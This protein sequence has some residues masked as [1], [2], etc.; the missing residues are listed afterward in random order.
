MSRYSQQIFLIMILIGLSAFFYL[1]HYQIFKDAHHIFIYMLGDIAFVFFEVML[2][3]V[4]IHEM[5]NTR[6]KRNRMEKLNVVIGIFFSEIGTDLLTYLSDFDPRLDRIKQDLC[7]EDA[8]SNKDF[9]RVSKRLK[10]YDYQVDL[11]RF[12]LKDLSELLCGKRDFLLRILENPTLLE[13]EKFT[14][15]LQSVFHLTEELAVR[16]NHAD[17]PPSDYAHLA[18]DVNRVYVHLTHQ[19]LDYMK[20]LKAHYP[21]L[22]SLAMRLNPFDLNASPI[23]S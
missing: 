16:L 7:R 2:V 19:W 12:K 1:L 3:T 11:E 8:W 5:L 21:H 22:F 14:E 17:L 18:V 15:L 9:S 13:H 6:D 10:D 4:I 20:H 23:V